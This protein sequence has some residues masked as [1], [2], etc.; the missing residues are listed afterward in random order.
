MP[1]A[2]TFVMAKGILGCSDHNESGDDS[3]DSSILSLATIK[4][5][6]I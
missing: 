6:S 2:V 1:L 3:S 4:L 5:A